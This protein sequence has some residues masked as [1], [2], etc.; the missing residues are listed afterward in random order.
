MFSKELNGKCQIKPIMVL[1]G[2]LFGTFLSLEGYGMEVKN[3]ISNEAKEQ[4]FSDDIKQECIAILKDGNK[5]DKFSISMHA[6]E[7]LS[8]AGYQ[9]L[10]RTNLLPKLALE[11]DGRKRCILARE[12]F[13][14]GDSSAINILEAIL[15]EQDTY[16]H[17]H[18]IESFYKI[19]QVSSS[20]VL[21]HDME[22]NQDIKLKTWACAP[23]ARQGRKD[24]LGILRNLVYNQDELSK[25]LSGYFLGQLGNKTEI[26]QIRRN[27]RNSKEPIYAFFNI[28]ALIYLGEEDIYS[29]FEKFLQHDD[30][31]IRALAAN[32][33][34]ETRL[35]KYNHL[36]LKNLEDTNLD[37]RVRSADAI[38]RVVGPSD[39]LVENNSI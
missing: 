13:R 39:S 35:E 29:E 19:G 2:I 32:T 24:A 30:A 17:I 22:Q 7:A 25:S 9:D 38:L 5:S 8:T 21:E 26:E 27:Y 31:T 15:Q 3:I 33:I 10:V 28:S 6:S 34:A 11:K 37:V 4:Q 12:L 1:T 16:A 18:A 14:A 36:L 20:D 23:L